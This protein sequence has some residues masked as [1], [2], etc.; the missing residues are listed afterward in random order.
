M[1]QDG[2]GPL[3]HWERTLDYADDSFRAEALGVI[4]GVHRRRED[5]R[6]AVT[7]W[8]QPEANPTLIGVRDT[9][10]EGQ[11]LAEGLARASA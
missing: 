1:S 11:A 6:W 8:P 9:L 3:L 2:A 10:E 5:G 4:W 7:R